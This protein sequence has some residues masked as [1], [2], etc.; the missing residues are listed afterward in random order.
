MPSSAQK[1]LRS[2]EWGDPSDIRSPVGGLGFSTFGLSAN[3]QD[4]AGTER[5]GE[6][7]QN[8]G[9]RASARSSVAGGPEAGVVET[10]RK[11]LRLG[12]ARSRPSLRCALCGAL[13]TEAGGTYRKGP[14]GNWLAWHAPFQDEKFL[15]VYPNGFCYL[16]DKYTF[17]PWPELEREVR[18]RDPERVWSGGCPW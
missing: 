15:S 6:E 9:A 10:V 2:S 4:L 11:Q 16:L 1:K 7:Q 5:M 13:V 8:D 12:L 17:A 14:K 3:S 18:R